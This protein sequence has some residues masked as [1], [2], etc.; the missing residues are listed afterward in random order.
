MVLLVTTGLTCAWVLHKTHGVRSCVC[1][2]VR[3]AIVVKLRL[4]QPHWRQFFIL[5]HLLGFVV[6]LQ[7]PVR[8]LDCVTNERRV[9]LKHNKLRYISGVWAV[10]S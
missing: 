6:V 7:L 4:V 1:R 2:V 9:E 5:S 8:A 3:H 10:W